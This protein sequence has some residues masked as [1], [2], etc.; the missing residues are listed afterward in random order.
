MDYLIWPFGISLVFIGMILRIWA[1]Q[2][3]HYRLNVKKCLT[4]T[5]PHSF[6]RNPVYVGNILMCLGAIITSELLWMAPIALVYWFSIYSFVVRYEERHLLE[7][8]G[9]SYQRYLLEVPRW[10]PRAIGF[11]KFVILNK[12]FLNSI[13]A[14][15]HC[16]FIL[17]PYVLKELVSPWFGH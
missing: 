1:Q 14:E 2:H 16:P 9:E 5:G 6:I 15:I 4:T 8:Y 12:Y 13:V 10:L 17:L 7:K 11:R 3:L